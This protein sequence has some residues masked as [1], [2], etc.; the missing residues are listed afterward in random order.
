MKN[1]LAIY[2]VVV[3]LLFIWGFFGGSA[4]LS[5]YPFLAFLFAAAVIALVVYGFAFLSGRIDD[6]EE[7][8][9]DLESKNN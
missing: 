9:K 3:V 6:L 2:G 5:K 8:I 4:L 1:Y 7:K